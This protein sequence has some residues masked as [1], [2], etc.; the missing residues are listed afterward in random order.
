MLFSFVTDY[1]LIK[2]RMILLFCYFGTDTEYSL[3]A[4][5][6]SDEDA[7]EKYERKGLARREKVELERNR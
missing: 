2:V 7:E 4:Q 6:W 1:L 3:R 5:S